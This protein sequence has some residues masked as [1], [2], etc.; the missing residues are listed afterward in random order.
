MLE[1]LHILLTYQCLYECDHCFLYCGPSREGTFTIPQLEAAIDQGVAAGISDIYI[2]GG[3]PFLYYPLMIE[4]LKMARARGLGC[5]VVTNAYWATSERDAEVWLAPLAGIGIDDLSISDD[6]FHGGDSENRPAKIALDVAARLGLPLRSI[7]IDEPGADGGESATDAMASD[8]RDPGAAV[9]GGEALLKGRAVDNLS[10]ELPRRSYACFEACTEEDLADPSR[11]HLDPFGN[12]FVCQGV[13]IG[14][15]WQKP[16]V[17]IMRDY[18]PLEHP[19][20]GPLITG[21][22]TALAR[23]YGVPDGANYASA[24]HLCYLVRKNLLD[25]F[26]EYLCPTQV[27]GEG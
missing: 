25:R 20:V 7:C 17:E 18:R 10:E 1:G 4:T 19:I 15:I 24:C 21:G 14:N 12:V 27:Y 22:P 9:V 5:G 8:P 16:L 23:R 13:S 3:E 11:V 26:P 2:E 6:T